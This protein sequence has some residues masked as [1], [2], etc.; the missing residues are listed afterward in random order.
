[1]QG[2][3]ENHAWTWSVYQDIV[4]VGILDIGHNME[5]FLNV[6][7]LNIGHNNNPKPR[8]EWISSTASPMERMHG[9]VLCACA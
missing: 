1:M 3:A 2:S 6:R 7:A 4:N 9:F 8:T 5:C